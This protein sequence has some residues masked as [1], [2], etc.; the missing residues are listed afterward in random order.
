MTSTPR[1]ERANATAPSHAAPAFVALDTPASG[2][3]VA[4]VAFVALVV[5]LVVALSACT[6]LPALPPDV[7]ISCSAAKNA[8]RCPQDLACFAPPGSTSGTCVAR[9]SPCIDVAADGTATQQDD[10]NSCAAGICVRGTC[11]PP[12]CGDGVVTSSRGET[13]DDGANN[14]SASSNASSGA[15]RSDCTKCG[16]GV[17]DD[18]HGEECDDGTANS[19]TK[20][21]ACRTDCTRARC[22]DG[23]VDAS[24]H[25]TCDPAASPATPG[26]RAS[27]CTSCG[28]GVVD[29][30]D[31]EACDDGASNSDTTPDACRTSCTL[32][33][34]GDGV[35]DPSLGEECDEGANNS[36]TAPDACRTTCKKPVC[37]DG[38]VDA[39]L[40]EVCD[41]GNTASGDGCRADCKKIERCGDGVVDVG[42]ECDD[43]NTNA[44]D[45]CDQCK[46]FHWAPTST[47]VSGNINGRA[48][49]SNPITPGAVAVDPLGRVLFVDGRLAEV[50]RIE[51]DGTIT[52]IAGNGVGAGDNGDGGLAVNARL[53]NPDG[54]AADDLGRIFIVDG[55]PECTLRRVDVDGTIHTA[56]GMPG[57][58]AASSDGGLATQTTLLGPAQVVLDR[59]GRPYLADSGKVRRVNFDGTIETVATGLG[60][61]AID[62]LDRIFI[63]LRSTPFEV[64]RVDVDG[65]STLVAGGGLTTF[66]TEGVAATD[67]SLPFCE[68]AVDAQGRL[69][70]SGIQ[71]EVNGPDR[72]IDRV[73]ADGTL[74]KV[75]ALP[76]DASGIVVET[77]GTFLVQDFGRLFRIDPSTT[78]STSTII[79]GS[80]ADAFS[81]P[82]GAALLSASIGLQSTSFLPDGTLLACD[83]R[84]D[85]IRSIAPGATTLATF[86]GNGIEA[87]SGD[88]GPAIDASLFNPVSVVADSAGRVYVATSDNHIRRVELD[89]TIHIIAGDG[90]NSTF[91]A[92]LNEGIPAT[93]ATIFVNNLAISDILHVDAQD[94]LFYVD[95]AFNFVRRIDADGTI[96]TVAG[97]GITPDVFDPP[98]DDGTPADQALLGVVTSVAFDAEG[99]M[100]LAES[101]SGVVRR[102][103]A[104]GTLHTIAGGG[105]DFS[106]EGI[107][108]T[109]AQLCPYDIAIDPNNDD[110]II[111]ES[112]T[113]N[114]PPT[115]IAATCV[116][117]VRRVDASSGIIST[118][119]GNGGNGSFGDGGPA[120]AATID[121]VAITFDR[122][123]RMFVA[124]EGEGASGIADGAGHIRV[125]DVD[126]EH[127]ITTF[128]GAVNPPGPGLGD[129]ASL[130]NAS[131]LAALEDAADDDVFTFGSFG[132]VMR[133]HNAALPS[134]SAAPIASAPAVSVVVGYP[135]ASS[136]ATA[137]AAFAPTQDDVGGIAVDAAGLRLF[138]VAPSELRTVELDPSRDG[139]VDDSALWTIASSPLSRTLSSPAGIAFDDA[140]DSVVVADEGDHCVVR[141]DASKAAGVT[142]LV[143]DVAGAGVCGSIGSFA[144]FFNHPR[145]VVV[146]A[147][148]AA[149]YVSDTGNNRVVRVD[150][151]GAFSVVLGDGSV[152]SAGEG[153]PAKLFPVDAP[154]QLALDPDGNLFITSRT[155]VR[156]VAKRDADVDATGDGAVFTIF[157]G[158]AR[159]TFPESA[160]SCLEG[161]VVV[162]GGSRVRVADRCQGFLVELT[163][164]H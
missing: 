105:A 30:A 52:L 6:N 10:G 13:C 128:A 80:G 154:G 14:A 27:S 59:Q 12:S 35:V 76:G 146:S 47:L 89:G 157:G 117:R 42:E 74:H 131:S 121:P 64:I 150:A 153:S 151:S 100:L 65:T 32:P 113:N 51:L 103:E 104:D 73:E 28:D 11:K 63:F 82:D 147:A 8:A 106:S 79:A 21:G 92:N 123:G 159:S 4:L 91:G 18:A 108:A 118:F 160:S 136:S 142:A 143:S 50:K 17:V 122:A 58:C 67:A 33:S 87:T 119:A 133:A 55:G 83:A 96:H 88:G 144:G 126:A 98:S 99:R 49:L 75:A 111:G 72:A 145:H 85:R 24:L 56:A 15:C 66:P 16:D 3:L 40:G 71:D 19:D 90:S 94:R 102:I 112:T 48:A 109:N 41:D 93:N 115:L 68:I 138:L 38:V 2:A 39:S 44:A 45:G 155:T 36:D 81:S 53:T 77:G 129:R 57:N 114:G 69:L 162:D 7:D 152:S 161:L 120:L 163:K 46:T 107:A 84:A 140:N 124:D 149:L 70:I 132:R 5:A 127:T 158:G 135:G 164:V 156:L 22:G 148:S 97:N 20:D 61:I 101:A 37:G 110:L 95:W 130:Y 23:V 31:G 141:V 134:S 62:A 125:I 60:E 139:V 116:P 1:T 54:V 25:E 137:R 9:T 34:C 43:G 26:C 29:S 78:P 86:A